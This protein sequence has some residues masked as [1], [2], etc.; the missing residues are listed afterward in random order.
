M[1]KLLTILCFFLITTSAWSAQTAIVKSKRAVIYADMLMTSPIGYIRKGKK[2]RIG[3]KSRNKGRVVPLIYVGK[4]VFVPTKDITILDGSSVTLEG[5]NPDVIGLELE[6]H[7][8]ISNFIMFSS[9]YS[10]GRYELSPS[11]TGSAFMTGFSFEVENRS[12]NRVRFNRLG[13]EQISFESDSGE[14][15][16]IPSGTYARVFR[17]RD[18]R[19]LKINAVFKIGFSPYTI[20]EVQPYFKLDGFSTMFEGSLEFI[21]FFAEK[22]SFQATLGYRMQQLSQFKL[23]DQF[24]EFNPLLSGVS[25]ILSLAYAY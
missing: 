15:L 6:R 7:R 19:K 8:F 5:E 14:V 10:K 11:D 16:T 24:E 17:L 1:I 3:N 20:Y 13:F 4:V 9:G 22:F 21:Y 25:S 18:W 2:V 23:D 12:S